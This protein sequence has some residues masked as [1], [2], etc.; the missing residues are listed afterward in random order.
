LD[1][2]ARDILRDEGIS[3][4]GFER[5]LVD[6]ARDCVESARG[7]GW[8]AEGSEVG[9]LGAEVEG[10]V[11]LRDYSGVERELR[12]RIDRV[13]RVAGL[14]RSIDYKTGKVITDGKKPETRRGHLLDAVSSGTAL[15]VSAYAMGGA[16]VD[17]AGS[18]QGR[19]LYLGADIP[20]HA[21]VAGVDSEDRDFADAFEHVA[22]VAFEAWDRGS[23]VPR[24]VDSFSRSEPRMCRTCSVKEACL[25]GDSGSRY[26]LEQWVASRRSEAAEGSLEAERAALQLWDLGV[27]EV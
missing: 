8:P 1:R 3:T 20:E 10:S 27:A 22:Q 24:L 14:L 16:Q 15:Q 2:R 4:P 11:A 17:G 21:R 9:V 19:Y 5:V 13:D 26:R 25:R 18:A 23:F 12:F 6:R 7:M